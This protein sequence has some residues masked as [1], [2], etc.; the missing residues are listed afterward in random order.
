M[1]RNSAEAKEAVGQSQGFD[2][3]VLFVFCV[4][5][6][7]GSTAVSFRLEKVSHNKDYMYIVTSYRYT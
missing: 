1:K 2:F 3:L 7:P 4:F 5:E 6:T